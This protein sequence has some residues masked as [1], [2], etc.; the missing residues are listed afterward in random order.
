M[1]RRSTL[2]IAAAMLAGVV[3]SSP[4]QAPGGRPDGLRRIAVFGPSTRAKDEATL[5]TFFIEMQRLGWTEGRNVAYDRVFA[6]DQGDALPQLAAELVARKP[7]LIFAPPGNVAM[8]ASQATQTIPIVFAAVSDPVGLGLVTSLAKPG[9]NVT[10]VS[11][12]GDSLV[13]KRIELLREMVPGARRLGFLV[14]SAPIARLTH[15]NLKSL[16]SIADLTIIY[17]EAETPEGLDA[18]MADLIK[19]RV[20]AIIPNTDIAFTRRERV[21]E[22]AGPQRIPVV[23]FR[24]QL[25]DEGALFGYGPSLAG[26]LRR[27]AAIVDKELR[28]ANPAHIPVEQP[29]EF[30]LVINVKVAK[31]IGIRI[32]RSVLLRA[33]RVVE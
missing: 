19:E 16:A 25:A 23:G 13:V 21:L 6:D 20:D 15:D 28:G 17:A 11:N 8:A 1:N 3:Q 27:S 5:K 26:Q 18:A 2:R 10:G 12:L 22:L 9:G 32:P 24:A 7:E 4:A 31:A 33:D 29:T 30:E 14:R